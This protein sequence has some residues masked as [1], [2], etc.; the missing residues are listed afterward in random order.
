MAKISRAEAAKTREMI[1]H[2]IAR[3]IWEET[4]A[5]EGDAYDIAVKIWKYLN[6]IGFVAPSAQ[7][8]TG[9]EP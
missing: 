3:R 7:P 8:S 2:E 4:E 5:N 6:S 9:E 1:L